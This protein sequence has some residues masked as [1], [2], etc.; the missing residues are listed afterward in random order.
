MVSI[1]VPILCHT[2]ADGAGRGDKKK[3]NFLD[4][5]FHRQHGK[6]KGSGRQSHPSSAARGPRPG[7][8]QAEHGWAGPA[9]CCIW[10]WAGPAEPWAGPGGARSWNWGL[11]GEEARGQ[12]C[13]RIKLCFSVGLKFKFIMFFFLTLTLNPMFCGWGRST[14]SRFGPTRDRRV[15]NR[16]GLMQSLISM[17]TTMVQERQVRG[18]CNFSIS[19]TLDGKCP[20]NLKCSSF[21]PPVFENLSGL[22]FRV[23]LCR[24]SSRMLR[25][26]A[27]PTRFILVD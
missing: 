22:G 18:F 19:S 23:C 10:S 3:F 20:L 12:Q 1:R 15:E 26:P 25:A 16:Q 2:M 7:L 13:C 24:G 11:A 6:A 17:N 4:G 5:S 14:S 9:G 21:Q 8:D 27:P